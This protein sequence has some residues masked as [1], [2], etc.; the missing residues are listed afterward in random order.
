LGYTNNTPQTTNLLSPLP[1]YT[2]E[3]IEAEKPH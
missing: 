1:F 3:S 2:A